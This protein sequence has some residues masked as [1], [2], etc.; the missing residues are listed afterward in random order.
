MERLNITPIKVRKQKYKLKGVFKMTATLKINEELNGIELYFN[1]KPAQTILTT[2]KENKFRWSNFKKCWYV[3]QSEKALHIASTLTNNAEVI[4]LTPTKETVKIVAKTKETF[5]LWNATRWEDIN[6]SQTVKDQDTK[7]ITKEIRSH[8]KKRF[9]GCKFSVTVPYYGKISAEIKSSPYEKDSVYLNEIV[10]YCDN[11]I[12]AY[13]HC[14]SAGDS[15]SDI[16]ASLNFYFFNTSID[17]DYTQTEATEEI[18]KD[19]LVFDSNLVTHERAEEERK[20]VEYKEW[21]KQRELETIEF[22]KRQ[23]EEKKREEFIYNSIETKE[24]NETDQYFVIRS[25]FAKL[26]KNNTLNQYKE[27]VETGKYNLQDVKI[28]KEIHF[29]NEEALNNFSNMLLNDFD[30]LSNTGGSYTDDNRINS[31]TDYYNMDEEEKQS[32]K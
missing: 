9:P 19:I 1:S 17:Y 3:K 10:G 5:N 13:Q 30:F 21:E 31:M 32:V 7:A 18:K 20:E 2:L 11:L 28:T 6:V 22:N 23:E 15:Y 16:P 12:K 29:T 25:E 4:E 24:L 26:N 8:L 14:Y 27:E